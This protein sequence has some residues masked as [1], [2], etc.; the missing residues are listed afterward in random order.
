[1]TRSQFGVLLLFVPTSTPSP[2]DAEILDE[3]AELGLALARKVQARAMA[4]ADGDDEAALSSLSS[5]FQKVSRSVRQ[6]LAL[7]DRLARMRKLDARRAGDDALGT[8]VARN[9][10]RKGQVRAALVRSLRKKYKREDEY[11]ALLGTLDETIY[12]ASIL[13]PD[14]VDGPFEKVVGRIRADLKTAANGVWRS[15]SG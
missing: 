13:Y 2:R 4:A 8:Y 7:K 3:L 10:L 12:E 15:G 9:M 14:F 1:M 11:E 5:A 6:S